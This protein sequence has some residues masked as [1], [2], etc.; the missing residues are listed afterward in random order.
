MKH[1]I[2]E[3]GLNSKNKNIRDTY[4]RLNEF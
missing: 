2:N 1:R 3:L 4:G